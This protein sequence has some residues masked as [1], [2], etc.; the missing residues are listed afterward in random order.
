MVGIKRA[1][2]GGSATSSAAEELSRGKRLLA[3][4]EQQQHDGQ[5]VEA[6]MRDK[7]IVLGDDGGHP[8][9]IQP[10][11][12]S[13]SPSAE[14]SIRGT[15]LGGLRAIGD[16]LLMDML[17]MVGARE[18]CCLARASR[19]LYVLAHMDELW[20]ALVI[21][22]VGGKFR[23]K[24]SWRETYKACVGEGKGERPTHSPIKIKGV[25]SDSLFQPWLCAS[26][27]IP[28]VR[29]QSHSFI[30]FALAHQSRPEHERGSNR[31]TPDPP[32]PPHFHRHHHD[33]HCCAES[34]I[35]STCFLLINHCKSDIRSQCFMITCL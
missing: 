25:Y 27:S 35:Q 17:G 18:L 19:F 32:P 7:E 31:G 6:E 10:W 21:S 28:E 14:P 5:A 30:P 16:E 13:Y 2:S 3:E 29:N 9:G 1:L 15:S 26:L 12:N 22:S 11:G 4:M 24:G 8:Y 34:C 20:R 33:H 23:F